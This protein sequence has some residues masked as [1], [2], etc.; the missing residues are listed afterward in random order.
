[1]VEGK[2]SPGLL[3]TKVFTNV[4]VEGQESLVIGRHEVFELFPEFLWVSALCVGWERKCDMV[5]WW[6]I[7]IIEINRG[8]E[9]LVQVLDIERNEKSDL[10]CV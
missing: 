10:R 1:M 2:F 3:W 6:E 9:R 7:E 5:L 8:Y 4:V